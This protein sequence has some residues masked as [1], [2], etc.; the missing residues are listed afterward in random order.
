MGYVVLD[1]WESPC[2]AIKR[3][4]P[5]LVAGGAELKLQEGGY[6]T[7]LRLSSPSAGVRQIGDK[8]Q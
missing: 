5:G 2:P 3:R 8:L 4:R 6:R 1:G 7:P